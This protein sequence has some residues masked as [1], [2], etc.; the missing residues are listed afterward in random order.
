MADAMGYHLSP[1]RGWSENSLR[2]NAFRA[3]FVGRNLQP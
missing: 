3:R 1:L 2:F